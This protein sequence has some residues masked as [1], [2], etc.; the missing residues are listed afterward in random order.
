MIQNFQEDGGGE[1]GL[2]K[3]ACPT[4]CRGCGLQSLGRWGIADRGHW[5]KLGFV[6]VSLLL[7]SISPL[8]CPP[9]GPGISGTQQLLIDSVRL[10]FSGT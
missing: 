5:A 10:S 2:S 6:A 8:S 1:R 7:D 9:S 3:W 4:V